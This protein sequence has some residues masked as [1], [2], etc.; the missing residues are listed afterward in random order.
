MPSQSGHPGPTASDAESRP[1]VAAKPT[2][3]RRQPPATSSRNQS[4]SAA[5]WSRLTLDVGPGRG[6]QGVRVAAVAAVLLGTTGG[7]PA[8]D[9]RLRGLGVEL[10]RRGSAPP[11]ISCG[12][13]SVRGQHVEPLGRREHVV[14]PLHP[15]ARGDR[16]S[17]DR[18]VEPPD[19]RRR[20]MRVTVPPRAWESTWAPKQIASS[21]TSRATTW[22]TSAA[23]AS[24]SAGGLRPVHVP[25][26]A[27]RQDELD[28][29]EARPAVGILPDALDEGVAALAQPV[30]DEAGVE[31][32]DVPDH[33]RAHDRSVRG[34]ETGEDAGHGRR[35]GGDARRHPGRQRRRLR[36]RQAHPDRDVGRPCRSGRAATSC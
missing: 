24:T 11:R 31:A 8:A 13:A 21:G 35:R 15:R 36:R 10:R 17:G 30:T 25:L 14:V 20:P 28:A 4:T 23:S 2:E 1:H 22:R 9:H 5:A 29:V 18:E 16:R 32:V 34:G 27:E 26:R 12:P 3:K 19:L 6:Q 33:Q 7:Q